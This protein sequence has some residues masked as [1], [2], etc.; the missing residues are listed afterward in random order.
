MAAKMAPDADDAV[1]DLLTRHS[2]RR[3]PEEVRADR[4]GRR[5]QVAAS[6]AARSVVKEWRRRR[7]R[8]L[9][10]V[11]PAR[12]LRSTSGAAGGDES[13]D[14]ILQ[15]QHHNTPVPAVKN[16]LMISG[17]PAEIMQSAEN[18]QLL[19]AMTVW[20]YNQSAYH[21]NAFNRGGDGM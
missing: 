9:W 1:L 6:P 11:L 12:A 18:V 10:R 14:Q 4:R 20:V 5:T 7:E 15:S 13:R 16:N 17:W 3:R 8:E 21:N 19:D 2:N